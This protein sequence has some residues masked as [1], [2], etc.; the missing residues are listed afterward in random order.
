[1]V[2]SLYCS[3]SY[4]SS[5]F[6]LALTAFGGEWRNF[7]AISRI[8]AAVIPII[9]LFDPKDVQVVLGTK[10]HLDKFFLMKYIRNIL[11]NGLVTSDSKYSAFVRELLL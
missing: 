10:K 11:G 8:W 4:Q 6:L 9:C 2:C 3:I 1:M 7:G 5:R